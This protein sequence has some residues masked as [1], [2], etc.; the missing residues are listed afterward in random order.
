MKK[1]MLLA[2]CFLPA[3]LL[4]QSNFILK[5]KIGK[6][7]APEKAYLVYKYAGKIIKDS[8]QVNRGAFEFKGNLKDPLVAQLILD[9]EGVGLNK[10]NRSADFTLLYLDK[11]NMLLTSP[12]SVKK[13][14]ISG[15]KINDENLKYKAFIAAPEQAIV[16][17]N[18]EYSI[19]PAD[20]KQDQNFINDLQS[21]AD[22]LITARKLLQRQ[23]IKQNPDSYI[24]LLALME[25]SGDPMDAQVTEPLYRGLTEA[26]RNTEAGQSYAKSLA[27]KNATDIGA[28]APA[29]TLNDVNDKPVSL[30]AF[31]GKYVLLDFWAS[32]C[33]PC[34]NENPNVVKVYKQYKEKNF[35]VL[36]VSL[37]RPGKKNDWLAAIK[38]DGL[39]WTQVSDLKFWNS[40]VAK[41]YGVT[42][43]P[44]NYLIDPNGKIIGKNLRGEEL[45]QKL[46]ELLN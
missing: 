6:G 28:Q 13:A 22:K 40:E 5:A 8:V 30:S 43:I 27:S 24:S 18:W 9:H 4:A 1:I 32:W 41:L 36:G 25:I 21:R 19:A 16:K 35:T 14:T 20:K 29:F 33:V 7:D 23:F 15:S 42:A 2:F 45:N 44:Q 10:L 46:A 11:G 37:D 17:L 31:K 39:E 12:D 26:I 3:S 38:A 34:R